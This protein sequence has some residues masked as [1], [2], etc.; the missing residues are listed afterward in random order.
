MDVNVNVIVDGE[1]IEEVDGP[2]IST[3]NGPLG[4]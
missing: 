3:K 4:P 1:G 2:E